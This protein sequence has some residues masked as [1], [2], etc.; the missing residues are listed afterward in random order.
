MK[1]L[2]IGLLALFLTACGSGKKPADEQAFLNSLDSTKSGPTIDEE[3]INSI[4]QQIPSPL[5]ISVLLKESG[6]KYNASILNS[7]DNLSKYNSNYKKALNLGV[8]GT[9]L[10]YTNIYEQ[11]KDGIKYLS[12][13]KSLADG[14]NIGQFF[15]IETIGHLAANSKNL[16][17]LLLITTQNFNSINHYLQTQSRANLSVLLLIG[18]WVEAMQITC[19]VAAKDVKNKELQ[20]KIGEQKIILEQIVL[21]LSFYKDDTNM[22][23]LLKDMDELKV[24]FDKINIT[25]TYKESTMQIVDGV[26]MIK[27][28]ST[29]TIN[30]TE[31]DVEAIRS[32]TNSIRNKIIS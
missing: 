30:I 1:L 10:G 24:A 3:V 19:Q 15:D 6:T 9:D 23:S 26:A 14:L 17:S 8:Y 16:D 22:A 12:S 27:D 2:L 11:N 20:E 18:G 25:Y 31:Q 13:I 28:N 21:L 4:L 32:L 29:T 7:A 5:E